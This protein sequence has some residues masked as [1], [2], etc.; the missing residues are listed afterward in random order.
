M[1]SGYVHLAHPEEDETLRALE[2]AASVRPTIDDDS[3][4]EILR[5]YTW[6]RY[7]RQI[8]SLVQ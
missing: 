4:V 3:L 7:F 8:E 2:K 1:E 6:D 5:D